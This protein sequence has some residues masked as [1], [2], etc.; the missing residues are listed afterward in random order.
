MK[1]YLLIGAALAALSGAP[2]L[3]A[4]PQVSGNLGFY[5]GGLWTD[6]DLSTGTFY[7]HD[8]N[9][10]LFGGD[11]HVNAWLSRDT[12]IQ[13]DAQ[14]HGTTSIDQGGYSYY[15]WDGHTGGIF[16][17]HFS[18]RDPQSHLFGVFGGFSGQNNLGYDGSMTHGIVGVEGQ[19][20]CDNAT[21]YGQVGYIPLM[22]D[23]DEYEPKGIWFLRGVGRYFFTDNDRLQADLSYGGSELKGDYDTDAR[24]W[25]LSLAWQHR[26]SDSPFST[27]IAYTGFWGSSD[28]YSGIID[29]DAE[30][31]AIT[32]SF[33]IHFGTG[34]LKQADREGETLDMPDFSRAEAWTYWLGWID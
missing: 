17:A 6:F 19:Y 22:S 10:F 25:N 7:G 5:A 30:E 4:P 29:N 28:G 8:S 24:Y 1:T 18:W 15:D 20:Y 11:A 27:T 26:Y 3:A 34:S 12:S 9:A 31:H 14:G 21:I 16:G 32:A 33:N 23:S 2:A 13:L